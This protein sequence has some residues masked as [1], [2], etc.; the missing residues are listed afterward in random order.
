MYVS[1]DLII[2]IEF[3]CCCYC[4]YLVLLV[5]FESVCIDLAKYSGSAT[6][7]HTMFFFFFFGCDVLV[8]FQKKI[9]QHDTFSCRSRDAIVVHYSS[10]FRMN[11]D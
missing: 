11:F 3:F 6:L 7:F 9:P 2:L 8:P 4:E 5:Q 10:V 1:C